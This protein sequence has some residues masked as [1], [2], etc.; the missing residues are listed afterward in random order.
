MHKFTEQY[1]SFLYQISHALYQI[2][3]QLMKDLTDYKAQ[4][5]VQ[6]KSSV[7]TLDVP[8]TF[9]QLGRAYADIL[10]HYESAIINLKYPQF[11]SERSAGDEASS[12]ARYK[13][14]EELN[15]S[16]RGVDVPEIKQRKKKNLL[17]FKDNRTYSCN[18]LDSPTKPQKASSKKDKK[19]EKVTESQ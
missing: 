18:N 15:L 17:N 2:F 14:T 6:K 10:L 19:K 12:L 7:Q 9:S 1:D 5:R 13:K 4:R 8:V 3:P 11:K 16:P